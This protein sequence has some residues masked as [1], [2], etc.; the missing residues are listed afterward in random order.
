MSKFEIMMIV[1]VCIY[2]SVFTFL[3]FAI[4]RAIMGNNLVKY[5]SAELIS[6]NNVKLDTM[7][8]SIKKL[9]TTIMGNTSKVEQS[10]NSHRELT[11]SLS[12]LTDEA[13]KS[14]NNE[15]GG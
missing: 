12:G 14:N 13:R 8:S 5:K 6:R 1:A 10:I 15:A 11:A 3:L 2:S 7:A 4:W 9:D